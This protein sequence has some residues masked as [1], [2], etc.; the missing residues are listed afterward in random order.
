MPRG[1]LS[2]AVDN[3]Q[4]T[5][6]SQLLRL[7]MP[8]LMMFY[9]KSFGSLPSPKRGRFSFEWLFKGSSIFTVY[10]KRNFSIYP[11]LLVAMFFVGENQ[12]TI[13]ISFFRAPLQVVFGIERKKKSQLVF[14]KREMVP[15]FGLST[16][17][18][19]AGRLKSLSDM[20]METLLKIWFERNQRVLKEIMS[21]IDMHGDISS[22]LFCITS[23]LF[24]F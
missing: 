3:A 9:F 23:L 6:L 12:R 24:F 4:P 17:F 18:L 11:S 15:S 21:S 8:H 5:H 14:S 7:V 1:G 2:K 10:C 22:L 13:I 19:F 20:G 16:V